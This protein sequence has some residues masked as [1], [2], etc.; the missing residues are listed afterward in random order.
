[1]APP[2]IWKVR[3]PAGQRDPRAE[4]LQVVAEGF[5]VLATAHANPNHVRPPPEVALV[6]AEELDR[7]NRAVEHFPRS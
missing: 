6:E 2:K 1:M 7:P 4:C 5:T 3:E